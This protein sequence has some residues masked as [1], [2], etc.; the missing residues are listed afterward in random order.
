MLD[1]SNIHMFIYIGVNKEGTYCDLFIS[2]KGERTKGERTQILCKIYNSCF[3]CFAEVKYRFTVLQWGQ[4]FLKGAWQP[5]INLMCSLRFRNILNSS[6]SSVYDDFAI[7]GFII[8]YYLSN[9]RH[10]L[11][12]VLLNCCLVWLI[13]VLVAATAQLNSAE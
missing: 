4:N 10:R 8:V 5:L 11:V 3:I 2:F 13:R 9:S 12:F 7:S 6:M 1:S